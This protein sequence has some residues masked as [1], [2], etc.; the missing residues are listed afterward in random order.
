MIF[1]GIPCKNKKYC[2]NLGLKPIPEYKNA[3]LSYCFNY[4]LDIKINYYD[5]KKL[6]LVL[7]LML[8][9]TCFAGEKSSTVHNSNNDTTTLE[10]VN[11]STLVYYNI[12]RLDI[13][14]KG[15]SGIVYIYKLDTSELVAAKVGDF[16]IDLRKGNYLVISTKPFTSAKAKVIEEFI[17]Y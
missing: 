9:I 2:L 16:T 8:S 11:D 12:D 7:T 14:Q 13:T 6:L 1:Q 5:M 3:K 4:Y 10:L 17:F 15:R